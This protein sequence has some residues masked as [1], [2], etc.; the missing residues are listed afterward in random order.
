MFLYVKC[1][2]VAYVVTMVGIDRLF[3]NQVDVP[4]CGVPY[5][6]LPSAVSS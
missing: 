6:V 1:L 2:S 5:A 4:P 3:L